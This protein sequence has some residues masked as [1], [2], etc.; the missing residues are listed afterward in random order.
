MPS[1]MSE[2][3]CRKC[4]GGLSRGGLNTSAGVALPREGVV[5][6]CAFRYAISDVFTSFRYSAGA[7]SL[8][9]CSRR[10]CLHRF[11]MT[12]CTM[13]PPYLSRPR[14][15]ASLSRLRLRKPAARLALRAR[16]RARASRLDTTSLGSSKGLGRHEMRL[17]A[18][19]NRRKR[20]ADS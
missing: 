9:I 16:A 11:A 19:M 12:P 4:K 7:M 14:G 20:H 15:W 5:G 8:E 1:E 17:C 2:P 3:G 13:T 18:E 6:S 10:Q